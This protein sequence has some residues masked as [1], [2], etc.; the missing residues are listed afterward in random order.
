MASAIKKMV[1]LSL[2]ERQDMGSRAIAYVKQHLDVNQLAEK[3][4]EL[5]LD[6][7]S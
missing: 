3:Y 4:T 6:T 2:A 1:S 7:I 5:V